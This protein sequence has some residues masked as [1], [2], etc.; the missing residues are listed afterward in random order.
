M[1]IFGLIRKVIALLIL[2][3]VVVPTYA[4]GITWYAAH[5]PMV[6]NGDAIVVLGAAQ[7]N[8]RPGD[9]LQ[10]RL[11]E[12]LRIYQLGIAPT[13]IT[14][15][16]N[17]PGDR[18]TEAASGK[19]WLVSQG[20]ARKH[21]IA[22]EVGRDTYVSTK[23]YAEKMKEGNLKNVIIVTDPYHCKRAMVMA[24]DQGLTSSCS[25]VHN[26]P[27]SLANSGLR[28]LLRESGAYLAYVTLVRRGVQI[29]DHLG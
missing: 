23:S 18:T 11:E 9:V 8:G 29:S 13:I 27:N 1:K 4:L 24:N 3:I 26:G 7:L 2:I 21:I 17:A 22:L 25:P 6:R 14:V 15:G 19:T 5:K 16:A 12:A 28:Y 20:V 10:A